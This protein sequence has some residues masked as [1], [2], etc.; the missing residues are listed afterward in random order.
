[1]PEVERAV[2]ALLEKTNNVVLMQC[3]T[4]YTASAENFRYVNLNVLKTYSEKFPNLVL[5]LSD[6]TEG[7][8]TVLGAVSL[9]AR[10]FEKHFTDDNS[11]E[12]PDH[13][14]AMN[15]VSWREMVDRANEVFL[16]LGDGEKRIEMNEKESAVV[17]RRSLWFSR[18]LNLGHVLESGD[19]VPLR[20]E[21]ADGVPP[22]LEW[23]LI[24]KKLIRSV[25]AGDYIRE[26]VFEA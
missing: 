1:M 18:R 19:L 26:E 13:R 5:G 7:H 12:G 4:N 2:A 23:Q 15:P 11:R 3:N 17:Q 25:S 21:N 22:Y 9:G 24:G 16:A 8:A 14:F 6:H 20:P 10:V